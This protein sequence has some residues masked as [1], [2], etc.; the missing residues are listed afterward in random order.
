MNST[1]RLLHNNKT[2]AEE[3]RQEDPEFFSR[4]EK[5]QSPEFLWIGCSDSRVPANE[6]T[7]THPGECIPI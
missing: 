4:L 7:G 5:L 1:E 6:I 2:W 3:T